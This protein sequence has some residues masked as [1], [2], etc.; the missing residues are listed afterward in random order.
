MEKK[1]YLPFPKEKQE[2][3]LGYLNQTNVA[4]YW[5]LRGGKRDRY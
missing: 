5:D 1:M 2:M 3:E 4:R